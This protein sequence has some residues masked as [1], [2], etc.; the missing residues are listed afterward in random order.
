MPRGRKAKKAQARREAALA[1]GGTD[2]V[3]FMP[4]GIAWVSDEKY[5]IGYQ[6][7]KHSVLKSFTS[8]IWAVFLP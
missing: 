2:P 3:G 1:A 7:Y 8:V 6:Y 5:D 4:D